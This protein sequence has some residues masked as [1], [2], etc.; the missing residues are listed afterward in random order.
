MVKF[1]VRKMQKPKSIGAKA[2]RKNRKHIMRGVSNM[3]KYASLARNV[4][5]LKAVVNAEKKESAGY[6]FNFSSGQ[7]NG[8][9]G[10]TNIFDLTPIIAQN[11]TGQGRIGNSIKLHS[12]VIKGQILQMQ[13]NHHQGR[14]KFMIFKVKGSTE[15][16]PLM[17]NLLELNPLNSLYDYNSPRALDTFK[18]YELI[19]TKSYNLQQDNYSGVQAW[20]DFVIPLKFKNHHIKYNDNNGTSVTNGQLLMICLADSGNISGTTTSTQTNIPV[21]GINSGFSVIS[22]AKAWFYDN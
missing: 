5:F 12:L 19:Q 7:V 17:S 1:S 2:L 3:N 8:N 13:N 14:L 21:T 11:V 18:N 15:T 16:T 22:Y 9:T 6:I 4:A 10:V 20:K